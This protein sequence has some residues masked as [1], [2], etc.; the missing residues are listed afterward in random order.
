MPKEKIFIKPK[1][2]LHFKLGDPK[3]GKDVIF[4]TG[5]VQEVDPADIANLDKRDY[6]V[7]TGKE[8]VAPKKQ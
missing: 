3:T 4:P 6:D 1:F 2:N 5:K 8:A 7:V